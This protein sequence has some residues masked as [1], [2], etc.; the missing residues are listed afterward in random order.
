MGAGLAS[1]RSW[2]AAIA[3][4][5]APAAGRVR[6]SELNALMYLYNQTGGQNW[7]KR[8]HWSAHTDPCRKLAAPVP[9]RGTAAGEWSAIP[10]RPGRRYEPTPWHG[11]GCIDPCDDYLDGDGCTAGRIVSLHLRSN[12]LGPPP[13]GSPPFDWSGLGEMRNLTL[14]DLSYN[15][16]SGSIPTEIG[17]INNIEVV[18]LRNNALF[19]E[20]P[21]QIGSL[22]ANGVGRLRELSL[23]DNRLRG[24]LPPSLATHAPSLESF[25]VGHNR[26]L[27]GTLPSS[28]TSLPAL[29]VLYLRNNSLSG[30][31]PAGM[32]AGGGLQKLRYLELWGN[33]K[34]S[35]TLPQSLGGLTGLLNLD[36]QGLRLSG[37]LP[38]EIGR[39][40]QLRSLRLN[41]NKLSGSLPTQLGNLVH[42]ETLDVW[43]NTFSGDMPSQL[44]QLIN[45]RLLYL[46]NEQLLPLRLH[47]CQHRLPN[48]GKYSYRLVR[49]EYYRFASAICPEPFD[50][51]SAFGTLAQLSGDV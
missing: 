22:N 19:G 44:G 35:G 42:L 21:S 2:A 27:S 49:E 8:D 48:L 15:S 12:G 18:S 4:L 20:L 6:P 11:V 40:T 34:V 16:L 41:D 32:G 33:P 38:T 26:L 3:L 17:L 43:N 46:P 51:L 29:Q 1:G 24:H 14:L 25:D 37:T 5:V 31:L 36:M 28:W 30:T 50:T 39:L 13:P 10:M 9:Y 47:Y 7:L 45:L 23:S